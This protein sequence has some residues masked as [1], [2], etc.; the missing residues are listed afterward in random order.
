MYSDLFKSSNVGIYR[1]HIIVNYSILQFLIIF[2]I[3]IILY[4]LLILLLSKYT[5]SKFSFNSELIKILKQ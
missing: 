2:N 4:L 3:I 1:T 5:Y